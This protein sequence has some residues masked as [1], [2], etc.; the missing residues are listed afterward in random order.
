MLKRIVASLRNWAR[1]LFETPVKSLPPIYG[2]TV[3]TDLRTFAAQA[4]E[5]Q[6]HG[7]EVVLPRD[8][9]HEQTK[10]PQGNVPIERL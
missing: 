8:L 5:A 3:P 6:H 9:H 2:D 4:E 1:W 10:V 7:Q